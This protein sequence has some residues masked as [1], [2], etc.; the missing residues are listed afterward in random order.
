MSERQTRWALF[1]AFVFVLPC[2]Y[3]MIVVA[4]ALPLFVI[5]LGMFDSV[6]PGVIIPMSIIHCLFFGAIFF[7]AAF[8]IAKALFFLR[9]NS[10]RYAVLAGISVLLMKIALTPMYGA[11]H[12]TVHP[13]TLPELMRPYFP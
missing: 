1:A 10:A 2:P 13:V 11:A 3:I 7:A 5:F 9:S 6:A 12:N 8:L 4:G